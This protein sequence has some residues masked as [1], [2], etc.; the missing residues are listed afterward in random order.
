MLAKTTLVRPNL[1][2]LTISLHLVAGTSAVALGRA[3]HGQLYLLTTLSN[4]LTHVRG[5]Y[6]D[7]VAT[8]NKFGKEGFKYLDELFNPQSFK[9]GFDLLISLYSLPP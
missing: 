6:A 9:F 4:K 5:I 3:N 2:L 8:P 1:H 7:D